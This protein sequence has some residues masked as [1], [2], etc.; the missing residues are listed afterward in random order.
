MR[1]V[2]AAL[3]AAA[4]AAGA[5]GV[6][7]DRVHES[8]AD[9]VPF[10]LL[11]PDPTTTS[12]VVAVDTEAVIVYL[13]GADRVVPV[14]RDVPAPA[15]LA[16]MMQALTAGPSPTEAA[17]GIRSALNPGDVRG[18]PGV[19]GGIATVELT[20]G[21]RAITPA[22]QLA[23]LAQI[24]FSLTTRPGVGRVSFTLDGQPIEVPRGDGTLTSGSVAREEYAQ[25]APA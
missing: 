18:T 14:R 10:D 16:D 12:T 8:G 25:L 2:A 22:D 20:G 3:I 19:A 6:G 17:S 13:F 23:T 21:F 7:S 9:D 5:C 4:L 15:T 24:V 11:A 1:R